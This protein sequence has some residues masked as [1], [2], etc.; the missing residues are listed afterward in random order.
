MSKNNDYLTEEKLNYTFDR[1]FDLTF[2]TMTD[3]SSDNDV[4]VKKEN[5]ILELFAYEDEDFISSMLGKIDDYF[6]KNFAKYYTYD[7][8]GR[9][10]SGY[11]ITDGTPL[12]CITNE[13]KK[14]IYYFKYNEE[15][16][17]SYSSPVI[18]KYYERLSL[19]YVRNLLYSFKELMGTYTS[20]GLFEKKELI[21]AM[22]D[23]FSPS[24]ILDIHTYF[25]AIVTDP[26][27]VKNLNK[28]YPT[29]T[30]DIARIFINHMSI[31]LTGDEELNEQTALNETNGETIHMEY[32][33]TTKQDTLKEEKPQ[34]KRSKFMVKNLCFPDD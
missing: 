9:I 30:T 15:F 21:Y 27:E 20:Y 11:Y 33:P 10:I 19:S 13:M 1:L 3:I 22:L 6:R 5:E 16:K 23:K 8:D 34:R 12:K 2:D 31:K 17:K 28:N 14:Y 26:E 4:L 25:D 24:Q 18:G 29:F 32:E 7:D